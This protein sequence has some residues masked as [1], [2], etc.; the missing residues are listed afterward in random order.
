MSIKRGGRAL[1]VKVDHSK[2]RVHLD[3][4]VLYTA[5]GTKYMLD[6]STT[7]LLT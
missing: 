1:V 2:G 5:T 7:E 6:S 4:N 3:L